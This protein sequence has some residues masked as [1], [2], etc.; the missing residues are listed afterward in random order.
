MVNIAF[1][2]IQLSENPLADDSFDHPGSG[3]CAA[4]RYAPE[5]HRQEL[6]PEQRL[7][8]MNKNIFMHLLFRR[9]LAEVSLFHLDAV[10]PFELPDR[11]QIQSSIPN[12]LCFL[13]G[14]CVDCINDLIAP[15]LFPFPVQFRLRDFSGLH[16]HR[17][18]IPPPELAISKRTMHRFQI[19]RGAFDVYIFRFTI[20]FHIKIIWFF[21]SFRV[22]ACA[23]CY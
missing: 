5:L 17:V 15:L 21:N 10:Y 2:G 19:E 1:D 11:F 7:E 14:Y 23:L 22:Q 8:R 9:F 16:Q 20:S 3:H 4:S 12:L 18:E 6:C 13:F